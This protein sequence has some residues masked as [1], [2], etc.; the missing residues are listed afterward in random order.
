[1]ALSNVAL[2]RL[3][4]ALPGYSYRR[5]PETFVRRSRPR[6]APVVYCRGSGLSG[7]VRFHPPT[8]GSPM[9]A[10][11]TAVLSSCFAIVATGAM[12]QDAMKKDDPMHKDGMSKKEMTMKECKDHMAMSDKDG[13]KKSDAMMKMDKMCADMMKK[14]PMA[15]DEMMKKD[16]MASDAMKK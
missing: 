8:K 5:K 16:G 1:L 13:M 4:P 3:D 15:K 7:Q 14:D 10:F 6:C 2:S 11:T 9:N 12:A